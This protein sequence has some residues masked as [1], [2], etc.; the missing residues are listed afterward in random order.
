MKTVLT[1]LNVGVRVMFKAIPQES[2]NFEIVKEWYGKNGVKSRLI[3]CLYNGCWSYALD[4][5]NCRESVDISIRKNDTGIHID[6]PCII[7]KKYINE[8]RNLICWREA[9]PA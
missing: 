1:A 3:R 9:Q 6:I 4:Y 7:P 5:N 2:P 8:V